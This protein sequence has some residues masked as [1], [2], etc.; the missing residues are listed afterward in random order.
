MS[1]FVVDPYHIRFLVVRAL[2]TDRRLA[3]LIAKDRA[4]ML[5][6]ERM[7]RGSYAAHRL[8]FGS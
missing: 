7:R 8:E 2:F 1:A 6:L 4:V 5:E 3:E